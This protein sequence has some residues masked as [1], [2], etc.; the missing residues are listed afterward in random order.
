[1]PGVFSC[2]SFLSYVLRFAGDRCL[3]VDVASSLWAVLVLLLVTLVGNTV[4]VTA[5][6]LKHFTVKG[7]TGILVFSFYK[8]SNSRKR[9]RQRNDNTCW[10]GGETRQDLKQVSYGFGDD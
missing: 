3:A 7:Q 1:M 8:N 9:P 2:V 6:T 5:V 10:N 4:V